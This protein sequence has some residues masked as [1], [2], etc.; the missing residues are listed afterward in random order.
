MS[1]IGNISFNDLAPLLKEF[2]A[3]EGDT[4]VGE[5]D[6]YTNNRNILL[7]IIIYYKYI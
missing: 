6:L 2:K 7:F 3:S 1:A 4:P 5:T